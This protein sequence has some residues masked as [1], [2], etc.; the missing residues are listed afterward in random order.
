MQR[1]LGKTMRLAVRAAAALTACAAIAGQAATLRW[2]TTAGG[3]GEWTDPEMWTVIA[4]SDDDGVPDADDTAQFGVQARGQGFAD[5]VIDGTQA[6]HRLDMR[7]RNDDWVACT[8]TMT[9][10]GGAMLRIG[11]G[12]LAISEGNQW[13][14]WS[15]IRES[16][17]IEVTADQEWSHWG[18]NFHI[19]S[20]IV[21]TGRITV[22]GADYLRLDLNSA[23][24]TFAGGFV[25][26]SGCTAIAGGS[27]QEEGVIV[28]GPVGTGLLA[29]RG[30][31]LFA[32]DNIACTLHNPVL[33]AGDVILGGDNG[34]TI[35]FSEAAGATWDLSAA[36][37]ATAHTLTAD[38]PVV[39]GRTVGESGGGSGPALIKRGRAT[40]T[41]GGMSPNTFAGGLTIADGTLV[42]AKDGAC[43]G[44][45]VAVAEESDASTA[46]LTI[47]AGVASAI[48]DDATLALVSNA[49]NHPVVELGAGVVEVVGALTLD[50]VPQPAGRT[51]GAVGSG[52]DFE[53]DAW[54][55][56]AGVVK[57]APRLHTL[58][59][60]R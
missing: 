2:K 51:C 25:Q 8:L 7:L 43:G 9:G 5:P 30:G 17:V 34:G 20:S 39:I 16:V 35:T 24:S 54:F 36:E 58:I 18:S 33:L 52:A 26:Q 21:G 56:G 28:K 57:T 12:G 38:S 23:G 3:S 48:A 53:S 40:V 60:V 10:R 50:G 19:N 44:G 59:S 37:G 45:D 27:V 42:A 32:R 11:A 47:P 46:R 13:Q 14:S 55:A 31:R 1:M 22:V 15:S 29:L 49:G 6:C 4:G 41:L